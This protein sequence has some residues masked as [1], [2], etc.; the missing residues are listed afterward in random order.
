MRVAT[1]SIYNLG[2]FNMNNR[3]V[4]L[5]KLQNQL[6]TGRKILTPSDDPVS[7]AR[8]LDLT[9]A[10]R[11]NEQYVTNVKYAN[12]TMALTEA[13]LQHAIG[14][15]QDIQQLAVQSGATTLTNAEKRMV[16]ADIRGKYQELLGL[17][18]TTDGNG[19]YLFAGFKGDTKPFNEQGYG[20]VRYDGDQG[21]RAVQVSP[22]RQIPVSDS[23]SDI[24]VK[25]KNGN[26][27]FTTAQ[28]QP[29]LP[30][31]VRVGDGGSIQFSRDPA[32]GFVASDYRVDWDSVSGNYTITRADGATTVASHA[33]LV[34]GVSALGMVI[35]A[36]GNQ[37]TAVN[38]T[39]TFDAK[40]QA[41]GGTG[42]V[43]PGVVA[44]PVKWANPLNNQNYRVQ[45]HSVPDPNNPAKML[46]SYDIIDN[47]TASANY[48]T[49][50][51]DG[52]NYTTSTASAANPT[53]T[54]TDS[55][56]NP[57]SFPRKYTAGS[58]I[59]FSQQTGETGALYP[60]WDFGGKISVDGV[61]KDGDSFSLE[62]SRDYDLF[63]TIGDF[64]AAL[65]RYE[66]TNLGGATFQNK[67]NTTLSNLDN[68][69]TRIL[70]IQAGIGSRQKEGESVQGTNEDLNVQYKTTIS[71]LTD[72]DYAQAISDFTQT[73]TY[74]DAA[75]KSF[76]SIQNLS[77]FQYIS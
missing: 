36:Q 54:R 33:A 34:G 39:A 37:P 12:D 28:T 26:G 5:F 44:D 50:L 11:Q 3:Q 57:N 6:S 60:G 63:S 77:L 19:L 58:D 69:L 41:N 24:F 27:T 15:I 4:D 13:N 53:A 20:N 43:S 59:I 25:I 17:A 55:A 66:E 70:T 22:S 62:A 42:V 14:V 48:N 18:N 64:S 8:S 16:E 30:R 29:E 67:L 68:A 32:G 23:G 76:S 31:T 49:S 71:K 52:W 1:S 74:L 45:F 7:S 2:V 35:T 56:G 10:T 61:P 9:Q 65:E 21:Q 51:I 40:L 47:D 72:L 38:G 73:Q 75:R 46:T